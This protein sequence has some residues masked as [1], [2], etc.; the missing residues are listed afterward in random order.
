MTNNILQ[1]RNM[2]V[3][4]A[5]TLHFPILLP[6]L[7]PWRPSP[8]HSSNVLHSFLLSN[9]NCGYALFMS[10]NCWSLMKNATSLF[11]GFLVRLAHTSGHSAYISVSC[12]VLAVTCKNSGVSAVAHCQK[13]TKWS[14]CTMCWT[15]NGLMTTLGM[16]RIVYIVFKG[17]Y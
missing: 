2:F 10:L 14:L 7:V 3:Y 15:R 11:S 17:Q 8:G 9:D 5:Y 4:Y 13:K 1:V 6:F 12:S 16:V